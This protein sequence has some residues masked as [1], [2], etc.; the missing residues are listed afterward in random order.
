VSLKQRKWLNR[1]RHLIAAGILIVFSFEACSSSYT[2]TPVAKSSTYWPTQ[3]MSYAEMNEKWEG[4]NT[5]IVMLDG[6]EQRGKFVHADSVCISWTDAE[7]GVMQRVPTPM[8]R[9]V[10][11][12]CT[13]PW[14]GAAVGFL[15]VFA[16]GSS[17]GTWGS[18]EGEHHDTSFRDAAR[19]FSVVGGVAE[20]F[21]GAAVG[22]W[23]THHDEIH[24]ARVAEPGTSKSDSSGF[25]A[26]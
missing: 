6:T 14:D 11:L 4:G 2:L 9:R 22:T 13:H 12:S 1:E 19:V 18:A 24:F 7:S 3:Y 5:T 16:V 20:G 23:I 21:L 26:K 15:V 10:D 8:V 25:T 17:G